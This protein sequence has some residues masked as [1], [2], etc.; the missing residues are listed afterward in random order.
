MNGNNYA[1]RKKQ[2]NGEEQQNADIRSVTLSK[3]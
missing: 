1:V 3:K 2:M